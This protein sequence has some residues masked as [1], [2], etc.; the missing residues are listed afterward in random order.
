MIQLHPAERVTVTGSSG[1]GKSNTIYLFLED[2]VKRDIPFVMFDTKQEYGGLKNTKYLKIQNTKRFYGLLQYNVPIVVDLSG[3]KI[4]QQQAVVKGC[5]DSM[6]RWNFKGVRLP[7]RPIFIEEIHKFC[8]SRGKASS[9]DSVKLLFTEGRSRGMGAVAITQFPTKVENEIMM[10]SGKLFVFRV[11]HLSPYL[12]QVIAQ[13]VGPDWVDKV[14]GL[15]TGQAIYIQEKTSEH[16]VIQFP[17]ATNK[18]GGATPEAHSVKGNMEGLEKAIKQP[19]KVKA[20]KS[21]KGGGLWLVLLLLLFFG[22][23]AV[24]VIWLVKKDK[25]EVVAAKPPGAGYNASAII[26]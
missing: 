11:N 13:V 14:P 9:K 4:E 2:L 12:E 17:L 16:E 19:E 22:L 15:P 24:V 1:S 10:N 20:A 3:L 25:K 5:L 18:T 21:G 6:L 23:L 26:P 8:P 7:P